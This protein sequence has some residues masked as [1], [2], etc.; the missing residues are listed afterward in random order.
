[1][2]ATSVIYPVSSVGG[3]LGALLALNPVTQII[4]AYRAVLLYGRLPDPLGFGATAVTSVSVLL[5]SWMLFHK[6]EFQFAENI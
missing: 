2:F 5:V 4:E 3:K 6:A 1:M